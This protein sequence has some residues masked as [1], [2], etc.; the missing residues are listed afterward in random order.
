MKVIVANER[1]LNPFLRHATPSRL[2]SSEI[3]GTKVVVQLRE[4]SGGKPA[5]IVLAPRRRR[6]HRRGRPST[7]EPSVHPW[8]YA[9]VFFASGGVA[10]CYSLHGLLVSIF[11]P[12]KVG[13]ANFVKR[14]P[15][16]H[17]CRRIQGPFICE[18]FHQVRIADERPAKGNQVCA[19]ALNGSF[20]RL[21][22][23][24]AIPH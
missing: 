23:V 21:L 2:W 18:T 10:G 13:V 9:M 6:G 14:I 3:F 16:L 7:D 20:R 8:H 5:M 4:S 11:V 22:G 19:L 24:T 17:I 12:G 15:Y 1:T